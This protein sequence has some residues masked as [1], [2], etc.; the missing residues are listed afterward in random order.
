MAVKSGTFGSL[1]GLIQTE[2]RPSDPRHFHNPGWVESMALA[3]DLLKQAF[4]LLN[5]EPKTP[6]KQAS[7]DP[8]PLR[9]TLFSTY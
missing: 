6:P 7:E 2:N 9:T 4:L 3:E 8:S 1:W 5:K